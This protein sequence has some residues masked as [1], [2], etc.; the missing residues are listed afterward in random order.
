MKYNIYWSRCAALQ[1]IKPGVLFKK[2][3]ERKKE[4]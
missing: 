2:K 3:K 4:N 1:T